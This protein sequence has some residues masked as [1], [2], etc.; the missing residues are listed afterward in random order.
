M[1]FFPAKT[2]CLLA[3]ALSASLLAACAT[4][5]PVMNDSPSYTITI[6]NDLKTERLAPVLVVGDA[7]DTKIWV[8]SYVSKEARTQF[9]TGNP[10]PL[11]IALGGE[12]A[13]PG[14]VNVNGEITF[15]FKT[16]AKT[17]RITAM[18]HP[19]ITPDNYVTAKL[20]LANPGFIALE[21]FDIGDNEKR[22]TVERVGQVGTVKLL[23]N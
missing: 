15:T 10:A 1:N 19:D 18:V 16:K 5:T 11:A 3:M 17:A 4:L 7:D 12:H 6:K 22:M 2:T 8:G 23:R 21:R 13:T 14:K 9:T 20:D